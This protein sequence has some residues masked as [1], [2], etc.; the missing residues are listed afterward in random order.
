MPNLV[1]PIDHTWGGGLE[2]TNRQVGIQVTVIGG[3]GGG[4]V[5]FGYTPQLL[6]NLDNAPLGLS[7]TTHH[8]TGIAPFLRAI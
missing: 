8:T 4:G 2:K 1:S 5:S 6:P 3:G 7:L